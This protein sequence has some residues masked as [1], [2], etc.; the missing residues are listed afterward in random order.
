MLDLL[1]RRARLPRA[2]R[3]QDIGIASGRIVAAAGDARDVIDLDG[4]LVTP[5]LVEPHTHL[6]AV[7][8]AGEPRQNV[9]GSLF[10]GIAIWAERVKSLDR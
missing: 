5:A 9:T 3:L 6:D 7:L 8:T 2:D 4:A 1:L 10:E